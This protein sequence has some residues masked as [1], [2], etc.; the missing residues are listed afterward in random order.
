MKKTPPEEVNTCLSA[1]IPKIKFFAWKSCAFEKFVV[2]LQ[3][4]MKNMLRRGA[5]D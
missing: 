3:R 2:I 1:K 5:R 4:K